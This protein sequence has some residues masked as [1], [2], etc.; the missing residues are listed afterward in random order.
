MIINCPNCRSIVRH[1]TDDEKEVSYHLIAEMWHIS[2]D[3][4][5]LIVC[6]ECGWFDLVADYYDGWRPWYAQ[7]K[8]IIDAEK[9]SR[10][11]MMELKP[12]PFC[13]NTNMTITVD[14]I[15]CDQC[16][17]YGPWI[18]KKY[19]DVPYDERKRLVIDLWNKRA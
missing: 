3:L 15:Q 13:G 17:A 12:C 5:G 11:M 4:S 9:A 8:K 10:G 14:E 1:A 7:V 19:K 2:D 6:D 16:G 18:D